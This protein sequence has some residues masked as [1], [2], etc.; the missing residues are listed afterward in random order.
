MGQPD[1]PTIIVFPE[2]ILT[3]PPESERQ[4]SSLRP[5]TVH[6][7]IPRIRSRPLLSAVVPTLYPDNGRWLSSA[8]VLPSDSEEIRK[9]GATVLTPS[10]FQLQESGKAVPTFNFYDTKLGILLY[11]EANG[12]ED[13]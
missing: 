10:E 8:S 7:A 13:V 4:L 2:F 6:N 3:G 1:N 12:L 9:H 11:G 5:D